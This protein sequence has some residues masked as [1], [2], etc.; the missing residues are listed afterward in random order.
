MWH[1]TPCAKIEQ[2]TGASVKHCVSRQ[3]CSALVQLN[4]RQ[5]KPAIPRNG[6]WP[7]AGRASRW[8]HCVAALLARHCLSLAHCAAL[9]RCASPAE[10]LQPKQQQDA[11]GG[12]QDGEPVGG[13]GQ[14]AQV[15]D[16]DRQL[17]DVGGQV[18]HIL[19]GAMKANA[20]A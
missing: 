11:L 6:A 20:L 2:I 12:S 17:D 13:D 14:A 1:G 10:V 16:D 8:T 7:S 5:R 19:R 4:A 3:V 15:H 18:V 9:G